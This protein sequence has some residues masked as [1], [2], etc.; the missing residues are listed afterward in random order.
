[1]LLTRR[2]NVLF[3][4]DDYLT[5]HYLARQNQKTIGELIRLAVTKTY[6]TKGRINK[7]VNQDLK[8]S[9][10][11]GWKLL[12]NPQKPLNYKELVEHGRKY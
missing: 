8:S 12:I 6:T 2:T 4:E 11:S 3:T 7:K 5:L 10:K 9:L 1:M